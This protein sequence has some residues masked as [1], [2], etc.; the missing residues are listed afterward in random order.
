M[1]GSLPPVDALVLVDAVDALPGRLRKRLDAAVAK[2]SGWAVDADGPEWTVTVDESTAVTLHTVDGVVRAATDARCTCLLAPA[3]LHRAAVLSAAPVA[4]PVDEV[5]PA[6][7]GPTE[8][9]LAETT[10]AEA[11]PAEAGRPSTGPADA[12]PA[13]TG[14]A[15]TGSA[16]EP[17][18]GLTAVQRAAAD[19]VWKA[20]GAVLT[21]GVTGSGVVLRASLLRAAHDARAHG[22]HHLAAGARQVATHLQ[23]ARSD[24]PHYRLGTV[25]DDLRALLLLAHRLRDPALPNGDVAPLL[26]TARR[27]YTARGSLRLVGLCAVP[28]LAG[29]GHAGTAT[30][31]ADRDGVLWLVADI[32]PGDVRRAAATAQAGI[33]LGG[34][35]LSHR[36]LARA[37]LLVTGATASESRQLGAGRSVR[38]VRAGG[39]AWHEA[40]LAEL[41]DEPIDA[42]LDRAFAALELPVQD[43]PAGADLLFLRAE[44]VGSAADGVLALTSDGQLVTLA[45]T[46]DSPELAYRDN[47]R[48]L[49]DASGVQLDVIGRPDPARPGLLHALAVA[50]HRAAVSAAVAASDPAE[51][52]DFV[53]DTPEIRL[54]AAWGGH[55]DL[56]Y[57]RLH[58]SMITSA[59]TG[60]AGPY[61]AD[62]AP[63]SDAPATAPDNPAPASGDP[64]PLTGDPVLRLLRRH[65]DRTVEGGRAVQA[66]ARSDQQ[67]LRTT[68]WETGADLLTALNAAARPGRRDTFGRLADDEG[69]RFVVAWLAAA[70]YEQ[71]AAWALSRAAWSP[72]GG[73]DES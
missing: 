53:L 15:S 30:Y 45:I 22:L 10:P 26:G 36:E 4:A 6:E 3:C 59:G 56:G 60:A 67:L 64:A 25:T 34:G 48:V 72:T 9:G 16:A 61:P 62:P 11:A 68:R 54:P 1:S 50:P 44:I 27:E 13:E 65:L 49:A 38:A 20:A 40:P 43:R 63:T 12:T 39:A 23:D 46:I 69:R 42:Q 35:L 58:R 29:S 28:V 24:A 2:V 31:V 7:E 66:F 5:G 17:T 70:V 8:V 21:A 41:W 52:A 57:D 18:P 14:R 71:A 37:G 47:L 33:P 55:V 19:A 51:A 73:L 32:Y